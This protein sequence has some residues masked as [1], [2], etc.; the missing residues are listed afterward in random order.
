MIKTVF[1]VTGHTVWSFV[2]VHRILQVPCGYKCNGL[3]S[4]DLD[5]QCCRP[6]RPILRP[7]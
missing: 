3:R 5:R 7:G 6:P 1:Y 4:G 2:A